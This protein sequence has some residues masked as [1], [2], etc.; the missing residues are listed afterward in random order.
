MAL[1]AQFDPTDDLQRLRADAR[2][3]DCLY[4]LDQQFRALHLPARTVFNELVKI[5]PQGFRFPELCRTELELGDEKAENRPPFR[6][7]LRLSEPIRVEGNLAGWIRIEYE[8][9]LRMD[10]GV[11]LPSEKKLLRNIADRIGDYLLMSRLRAALGQKS[12]LSGSESV[13]SHLMN[14][15][16]GWM[17]SSNLPSDLISSIIQSPIRFRKG[18]V[19]NKQGVDSAYLYVLAEGYVKNYIEAG[20]DRRMIFKIVKPFDWI[21]TPLVAG[22]KHLF[23]SSMALNDV[24]VFPIHREDLLQ[25]GEQYPAIPARIHTA[26]AQS[27]ENNLTRIAQLMTCQAM[28]KIA[29]ILQYLSEE[30]FQSTVIPNI[31]SRRDISELTAMSTESAV[32]MLSTLKKD[33]VIRSSSKGL[34]IL[35]QRMLKRLVQA[36]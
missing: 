32:R 31:L 27:V 1:I 12:P 19:M 4:E 24:V 33:R 9:P 21:G 3:I 30:V 36:G 25:L 14:Q 20:S 8:G 18:E 29:T 7:D 26:F 17:E 22:R 10:K 6:T 11:F 23:F 15:I 13:D 34:E 2:H 16:L 35:D 5:I 28:G